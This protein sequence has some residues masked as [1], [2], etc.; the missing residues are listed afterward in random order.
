MRTAAI[1]VAAR[2]SSVCGGFSSSTFLAVAFFLSGTGALTFLAAL[3]A[4]A[5]SFLRFASSSI[6][7][8]V[9]LRFLIGG[10]LTR[11][12]LASSTSFSVPF[13]RATRPLYAAASR[14]AA[15]AISAR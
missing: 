8:S 14:L 15:L 7:V 4:S 11:F 5:F 3:T 10:Y 13:C 2:S 12:F 1:L 9:L 6:G